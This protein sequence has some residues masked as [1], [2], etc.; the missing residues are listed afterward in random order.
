MIVV[1]THVLVWALHDDDRLGPEAKALIE[2][3]SVANAVL[4]AAIT[5]W[6]IA[7]LAQKGRLALARDTADWIA[8]ALSTPGLSLAPLEPAIAVDSVRLPGAFHADPA[9]R[10]II[11]TARHRGAVLLTADRAI[12]D[13]GATG[14]V[15]VVDAA[16]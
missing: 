14:Q 10:L 11:A 1:D 8:T 12:L 9:D 16:R 7:M 3:A 2:Q 13:Y 15:R 4:V 5:P 6:E